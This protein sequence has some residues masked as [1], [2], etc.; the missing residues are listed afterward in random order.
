[1]IE[2]KCQACGANWLAPEALDSE[3]VRVAVSAFRQHGGSGGIKMLRE[4]W[5]LSAHDAKA[6]VLHLTKEQGICHRCK[7]PVTCR[8][9]GQCENCFSINYDW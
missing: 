8:P 1:M 5:G 7:A 6:I 4:R 9:V 3:S 2:M